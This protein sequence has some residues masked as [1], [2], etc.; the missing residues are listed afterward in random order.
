MN[1]PVTG[2]VAT[3]LLALGASRGIA[4]PLF[5]SDGFESPHVNSNT[6]F[7]GAVTNWI[8]VGGAYNGFGVVGGL[9]VDGNV[10]AE[11]APTEGTQQAFLNAQNGQPSG[12]SRTLVGAG[13]LSSYATLTITVDV[14]RARLTAAHIDFSANTTLVA[15]FA[16]D[17]NLVAFLT[18]TMSSVPDATFVLNKTVT[19]QTSSLTGAQLAE[20]LTVEFRASSTGADVTQVLLDNLRIT[21]TEQT[22]CPGD[23]NNDGQVDDADFVMFAA[24]YNILDCADPT[25]SAG[26]PAD[27]NADGFVDDS[28]FVGFVAAYNALLCP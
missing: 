1:Y 19:L 27:L 12:L 4:A 14:G 11:P 2:Y 20:P 15:G 10:A 3:L 16:S 6:Y 25:M 13:G 24:A 9:F 21:W 8:G 28:D 22:A 5:T 17:S 7:A 26:C 18:T 23:L